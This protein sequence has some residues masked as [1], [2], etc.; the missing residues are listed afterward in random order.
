[1]GNFRIELSFYFILECPVDVP[2]VSCSYEPCAKLFCL[3]YPE[4]VCK[5]NF[6]GGCKADFFLK[7]E[8]IECSKQFLKFTEILKI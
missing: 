7:G 4:A 2:L 8:K 5:P 6:C 3:D 1:M